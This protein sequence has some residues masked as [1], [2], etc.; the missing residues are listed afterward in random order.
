MEAKIFK[1]LPKEAERIRKKVFMEEQGFQNE[2]DE[3]DRISLH[4]VLLDV[5]NP[6]GTCRIYY[7]E[8]RQCYVIGRIA[9]LKDHRGRNAGSQL[10][11]AAEKE[12]R[13][14]KGNRAELL[15]QVRATPFYE[16]NRYFSLGD[17]Y[18]DEGCPHVWMRKE[19]R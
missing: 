4:V 1:T 6:V 11:K 18:M 19:L 2:F 7:S 12:I 8:E 16:K 9:V 5:S 15:A 10:L 3:T 17:I 13:K 14:R